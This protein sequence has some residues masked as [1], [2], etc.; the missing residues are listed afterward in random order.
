MAEQGSTAEK[1]SKAYEIMLQRVKTLWHDVEEKTRP[2]LQEAL[3]K[4]RETAYELG[5]L[6]REEAEKISEYVRKDLEEA[7]EF[8]NENGKQFKDWLK[9]DLE[10]AE[11][12]LAEI[13]AAMA[14]TTRI[15]LEKFAERARQ[16]GEWH[17]GE[18]TGIGILRCKGCGELLH[19]EKSGHI[20][21]CPK[22]HGTVF[23]KDFS[24]PQI[25]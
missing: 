12:K 3:Q 5:E 13:F 4:A 20:P 7:A 18:I 14:D 21:P 17:T 1:L 10:F 19:F 15:E 23:K 25:L 9:T 11:L 24:K 8:L 22:C 6:S 16:V 2:T